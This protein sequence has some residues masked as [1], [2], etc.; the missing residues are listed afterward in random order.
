MM[1]NILRWLTTN[2]RV[3]LLAFI[4]ALAVWVMAVTTSDP[5]RTNTLPQPVTIEF[6][7]QDPGLVSTGEFPGTVEVSLRAPQSVWDLMLAD[8]ASVR[9]IVDL[10][11]IG[12]GTHT[13]DVVVQVTAAPVRILSVSPGTFVLTLEPLSTLQLPVS[14]SL[15]GDPAIG[16]Q[17]GDPALTPS[18]VAVSGPES[19]VSQ[20]ISVRVSLD[21]TNA[22]ESVETNLALAAFDA[23]GSLLSGLTLSPESVQVSLP[24]TQLG[25][26]RDLAVKVVTVGRAASGYRLASVAAFP[27]IVTVY[28]AN[29]ALIESLPGYVETTSLDLS[30]A[31]ENIE[32][33]LGLLLPADVTLLGEQTVLVEVGISPIEDSLTMA[34]RPVEVIGLAPGLKAQVSPLTVDV[35]LSGPIPA[36]ESLKPSEVRVSIDAS[37][38]GVGTYQL[39]P[40]VTISVDNVIVQSILPST[41]Q[42]TITGPS[43]PTPR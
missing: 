15:T 28:S 14:I 41:V 40:I 16:Y 9:A 3:F 27:A 37:G 17:A 19:L 34:Y 7:G 42:V 38:Y 1:T 4:L 24:V 22:R 31:S 25:G 39:I 10:T 30:G 35:I 12:S 23:S 8:P 5:D 11:G 13:V 32:I 26:Y 36:L 33:R 6:V 2:L 20:V 29:D 43:T 21:L 18:E